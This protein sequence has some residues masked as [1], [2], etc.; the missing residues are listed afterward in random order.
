MSLSHFAERIGP[1]PPLEIA[2]RQGRDHRFGGA[3]V[4]ISIVHVGH[5]AWASQDEAATW[6][7]LFDIERRNR[8]AGLTDA[9]HHAE[10]PDAG[11][12]FLQGPT[13]NTV[14][15]DVDA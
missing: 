1:S 14:I 10:R 4:L 9:C 12:C 15:S 5:H 7:E 6:A 2:G 8:T 13:A 3:T 11:K